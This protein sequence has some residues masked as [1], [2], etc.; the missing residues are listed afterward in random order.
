MPDTKIRA[1]APTI[2]F[3]AAMYVASALGT[4]IGDL[5]AQF[6]ISALSPPLP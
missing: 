6:L 2:R 5:Y 1:L 4:N 3:L